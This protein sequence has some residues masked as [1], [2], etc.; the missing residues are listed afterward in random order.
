[1]LTSCPRLNTLIYNQFQDPK[2]ISN[3]V[4]DPWGIEQIWNL[5]N[6]PYTSRI[7]QSTGVQ[8]LTGGFQLG[9]L[10]TLSMFE[11]GSL[12]TIIAR[13]ILWN[14]LEQE[15]EDLDSITPLLTT[16]R[17]LQLTFHLKWIG[18]MH[19]DPL[20]E[21]LC[22]LIGQLKPIEEF[23]TGF[24]FLGPPDMVMFVGECSYWI[25][26][27]NAPSLRS[28]TLDNLVME[29]KL[30][31]QMFQ[32]C[33]NIKQLTINGLSLSFGDVISTQAEIPSVLRFLWK[34][35]KT[36]NLDNF[37]IKGIITDGW[38]RAWIAREVPGTDNLRQHI[39]DFVCRKQ[40]FPFPGLEDICDSDMPLVLSFRQV[41]QPQMMDR[42][43][44][45]WLD[46]KRISDKSWEFKPKV[47]TLDD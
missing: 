12:H 18:M 15:P 6:L 21:K 35:H 16:V 8:R 32:N 13:D 23:R 14:S 36:L 17:R 42:L 25:S 20:I 24:T 10:D 40:S 28:L 34:L 31:L 43:H 22:D 9:F 29:E 38:E 3:Q 4:E 45:W 46:V 37:H 19:H 26:K 41:F 11:P 1:M 7:F 44:D 47:W 33:S 27:L 39:E 30:L 5:S 2:D